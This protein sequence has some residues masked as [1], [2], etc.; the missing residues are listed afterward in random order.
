MDL[1]CTFIVLDLLKP[2]RVPIYSTAN[3]HVLPRPFGDNTH[4]IGSRSVRSGV[5][6]ASPP[7]LALPY[8]A[9]SRTHAGTRSHPHVVRSQLAV[10]PCVLVRDCASPP[11]GLQ[12]EGQEG[13]L[14]VLGEA[15]VIQLDLLVMRPQ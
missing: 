14:V 6:A 9:H 2:G 7:L 12:F 5:A 10:L 13:L 4:T 3:M 1:Q 15:G 8:A 11:A